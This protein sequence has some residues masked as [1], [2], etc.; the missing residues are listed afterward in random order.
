MYCVLCLYSSSDNY[1]GNT[2]Y[3]LRSEEDTRGADCLCLGV[4]S[5]M[6][7][8]RVKISEPIRGTVRRVESV[9]ILIID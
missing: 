7:M 9:T 4:G 1:S 5:E 3:A 6:V 8:V 2:Q